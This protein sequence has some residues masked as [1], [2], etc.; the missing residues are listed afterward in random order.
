MRLHLVDGTFE[1]YRAHYSHRPEHWDPEGRD[2]KATVGVVQSLLALLE[3]RDEAPT[4]LAIA[5]DNPIVCF[6]N[7]LFD[8]YKTD[9]GVPPELREQFDPVEQ[10]AAA[11]GVRVWSMQEHEADDALATA[12]AR[13]LGEVD[14]VRLL[15]PDKDLG[16]CLRPGVVQVDRIRR[17]V[18]D[19]A[20]V[21]ARWGVAPTQI[22][23]M[24][25]LT[26]DSADG[27]PGLPGFG[28]KTAAAILSR[29]GTLAAVPDDPAMWDVPVR[30]KDRL[31]ATFAAR[32]ADAMLYEELATLVTDAPIDASL[33]ALRWDGAPRERFEAWCDALG[34][35]GSLRTRPRRWT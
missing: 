24:L 7:R 1:L 26:G 13:F 30:G 35:D 10:A 9:E 34:V 22:P 20:A 19:E 25:A 16:Q 4:H 6:R 8:G 17:K 33:D 32:R 28:E 23:A 5:F 27:I 21:R 12:A 15:T 31:A 18:I 29:F 11:L 2:R 14:E 3:D